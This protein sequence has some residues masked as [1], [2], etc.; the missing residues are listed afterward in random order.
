MINQ[1]QKIFPSL[2]RYN[3][4]TSDMSDTYQWYITDSGEIIGI[5]KNELTSKDIKLLS[6]FLSPY[7][8]RLPVPTQTEK[9]WLNILHD[10]DN[11]KSNAA[12]QQTPFRFVYFHIRKNQIS[13]YAFKVAIH[14]LFADPVPILWENEHEGII[15][16]L[17]KSQPDERIS[18]EQIIDIL[19][20]DLN[21][22]IHFY[23][24]AYLNDL[25]SIKDYYISMIQGAKSV[26]AYT[27]KSVV[28]YVEAV[29]SMLMDQTEDSFKQLLAAT[30]LKEFSDEEDFLHMLQT[31]IRCN[32]NITLTA[33]ELY[34]HRNTLQYRLDKFQ[35]KTG[36]DVR[37]FHQA[38]TVY[39][40][41]LANMHKE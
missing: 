36:M 20:S 15:V 21:G 3:E 7:N 29:P 39:L 37:E 25:H 13:A 33:K 19:M 35:E 2:V 24:G 6:A 8:N 22:S 23:V 12:T 30:V 17:L 9:K 34:M 1:L 28:T 10:G 26:F 41:L 5:Q 38:F 11:E 40:A 31:F 18:Y 32:L 14:E 4:K 27:G 16:E